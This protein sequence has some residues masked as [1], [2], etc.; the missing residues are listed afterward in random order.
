[1][2]IGS[3]SD[4]IDLTGDSPQKKKIKLSQSLKEEIDEIIRKLKIQSR[5]NDIR[6]YN[7]QG[8]IPYLNFPP[9]HPGHFTISNKYR[10]YSMVGSSEYVNSVYRLGLNGT[11]YYYTGIPNN[12]EVFASP[13]LIEIAEDAKKRGL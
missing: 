12:L 3:S 13:R 9:G 10:L 2:C 1:M 8:Q 7:L 11:V 6:Y 5:I 4:P